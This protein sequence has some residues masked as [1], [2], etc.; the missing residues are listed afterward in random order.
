MD[1]TI[2]VTSEKITVKGIDTNNASGVYWPVRGGYRV[3]IK[4]TKTSLIRLG[5]ERF[6][7]LYKNILNKYNNVLNIYLI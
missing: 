1:Q 6:Y 2:Q 7:C 5:Y 4:L 3:V